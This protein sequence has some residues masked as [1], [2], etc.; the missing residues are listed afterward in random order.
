MN[1]NNKLVQSIIGGI[2]IFGFVFSMI[3]LNPFEDYQL[4]ES[5][6]SGV[7]DFKVFEDGVTYREDTKFGGDTYISIIHDDVE[8]DCIGLGYHLSP[9]CVEI[10]MRSLP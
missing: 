10:I 4:P 1:L 7:K 3:T 9:I 2:F 6:A 8:Y 5:N